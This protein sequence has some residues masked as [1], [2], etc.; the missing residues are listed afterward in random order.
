M[1]VMPGRNAG[2]VMSGRRPLVKGSF[3]AVA[4]VSGAVMS[5]EGEAGWRAPRVFIAGDACHTHSPKAGQG[6]NVSM[7]DSF[8]LGWKL[9]S[10]L[11][12]LS[13]PALLNT[14]SSE[15]RAVARDLIDFDREFAAM[16]SAPPKD[17]NDADGEGVDPVEFQKYFTRKLRFTAGAETRYRPSIIQAEPNF[18]RLAQGFVIGMRLHSAPAIRL[19]DARPVHLG[20]TVKADG[21]F[22]L[23]IFADRENPASPSSRA[24]ALCEFLAGSPSSPVARHTPKEA[25]IDFVFDVRAVFQQS[26]RALKIEDIP[27]FLLPRKGRYGLRDYE[28]MFCADLRAGKDVFDMRGVDRDGCMVVV[29]PDQY[30]AHVLPLDAHGELAA[31]FAGFMIGRN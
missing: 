3:E 5:I 21:R 10:A 31:F 22:R 18:Q 15:R 25:D 8:N 20:H 2:R 12:G 29:R 7:Q 24:R 17:A 13:S 23:F 28:K 27:A 4:N 6:M 1:P 19:A 9:A 14:Y 16:F 11:K 30:V 26:H